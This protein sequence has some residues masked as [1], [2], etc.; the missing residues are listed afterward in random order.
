MD[1]TLHDIVNWLTIARAKAQ[2]FAEHHSEYA[3][4]LQQLERDIQ[5]AQRNLIG[6]YGR[7]VESS[8]PRTFFLAHVPIDS[9]PANT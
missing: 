7:L 5:Q 2:L 3:T 1:T 4:A 8:L 6:K 9:A